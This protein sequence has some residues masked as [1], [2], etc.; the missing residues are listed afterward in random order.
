MLGVI[1]LGRGKLDEAERLLSAA[2]ASRPSYAAIEHNW[3]LLQDARLAL[4]QAQP[5]ELAERALP[6]LVDLALAPRAGERGG[7]S[8]TR[9]AATLR[10]AI[11][12]I[13]RV[14][15][16]EH[17]DGLLLRSL[18]DLL[19]ADTTALW[20]TDSNGTETMGARNVE[21]IDRGLGAY[22]RGGTHVFAGVDFDC[23]AWIDLA[24]ADRVIVF[25]QSASPTRYL[26]QL[27][28]IAHDG[29]RPVELVFVSQ[30]MAERFGHGHASL[31]PPVDLAALAATVASEQSAH[32]EDLIETPAG[33]PVGIIGQNQQFLSEPPDANFV[34]VSVGMPVDFTSTI[35]GA[36]AMFSGVA[37]SPASSSDGRRARRRSSRNSFSF[38][39]RMR[40]GKSR[41]AASCMA[42]WRSAYRYCAR[43]P[44]FTPSASS[45]VSTAC[46]TGRAKR[47]SS[48]CPTCGASRRWRVPSDGRSRQ[49]A[50][51]AR[52]QDAEPTLP[53]TYSRHCGLGR[54][55][56]MID[57]DN[58]RVMDA[59]LE[60]SE[61]RVRAIAFYLR[62]STRSRRTTAGGAPGSPS[63]PTCRARS[64]ISRV[65]TSPAARP[66]WAST[67]CAVRE[68]REQQA[69]LARE[70]GI[71]GFCYY[72]YWFNGQAP[73]RTDR[74]RD[75]T[76]GT[77]RISLLL[78]LGQRELD[79]ALGRRG[80]R[81]S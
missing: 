8:R 56:R 14:H 12:L 78:L 35:Q 27:R 69:A 38:I 54:E 41:R 43:G 31:P 76:S 39:A 23:A 58:G 30:R 51:A 53:R 63:G 7:A 62:S 32:D 16:E 2:R 10:P 73:A 70:H 29:A 17:D 72:H 81:R 24:D 20:A 21:R 13:G 80:T 52:R 44:P 18:A 65:T 45:T 42:P 22:P 48:I 11:H 37:L 5:E 4:E 79:P 28:A 47:R 46:S 1:E 33:W 36:S 61:P 57:E 26:D 59:Q 77:T 49:D 9:T 75:R 74:S 60:H 55:K 15:A 3:Q 64:R 68:T 6:I 66:N 40:G 67:T 50:G 34:R 71:H 19:G 25:C